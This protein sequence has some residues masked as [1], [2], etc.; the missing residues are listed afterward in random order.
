MSE[1]LVEN[2]DKLVENADELVEN[3]SEVTDAVVSNI[4]AVG[5]QIVEVINGVG[6]QKDALKELTADA[7]REITAYVHSAG[8]FVAEQTPLLC[9]EI[10]NFGLAK[11][12]ILTVIWLIFALVSYYI[13]HK[14]YKHGTKINCDEA[15]RLG[16]ALKIICPIGCSVGFIIMGIQTAKIWFAPRL[17][18]LEYLAALVN[19]T[20]ATN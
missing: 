18:I 17:Y 8:N 6:A 14:L 5:G 11:A 4:D 12:I 3:A 15:L 19:S 7:L 2:A 9:Q 16:I 13:A 20:N 10:I 1:K